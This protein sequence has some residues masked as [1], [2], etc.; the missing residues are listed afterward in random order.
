MRVNEIEE[1]LA[2]YYE[3]ATSEAEEKELK[4]YFSE[5]EV[6][7]HLLADKEFFMQM[8]L[9][10]CPEPRVPDGLGDRLS[11]MIDEWDTRERRTLKVNKHRRTL[12]LQWIASI[13]ASLLLLFSVGMYLYLP[14]TTSAPEDTCGTPEE[15]Y[16]QA[17]K[18]LVMLSASL[19]KG[20][21]EVET[22]KET[23]SKVRENVYQQLNRI[24]YIKQ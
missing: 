20:M 14:S 5:D 11:S 18:A 1:L 9:N 12:R 16:A 7:A 3:G 17:Q 4:R 15:A 24:N 23:T 22:V 8:A 6:P 10:A 2:R 19:N 21:N 13:A